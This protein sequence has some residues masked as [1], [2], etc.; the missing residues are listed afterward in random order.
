V[1][2]VFGVQLQDL[3]DEILR[4][5]ATAAVDDA[6]DPGGFADPF[7]GRDVFAAA[8]QAADGKPHQRPADHQ[9][10]HQ[11]PA[12]ELIDHGRSIGMLGA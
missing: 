6:A 12:D 11:R 5:H 2:E 10:D 7:L 8:R 3:F 1:L 9:P 4:C